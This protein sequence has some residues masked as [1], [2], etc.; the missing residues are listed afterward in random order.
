MVVGSLVKED[1]HP[2]NKSP[3]I[4]TITKKTEIVFHKESNHGAGEKWSTKDLEPLMSNEI[5]EGFVVTVR[6]QDDPS[7]CTVHAFYNDCE[8][9]STINF[10]SNSLTMWREE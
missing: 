3:R 4:G 5:R 8:G 10:G 2:D 9:Q 7:K 1:C 6:W